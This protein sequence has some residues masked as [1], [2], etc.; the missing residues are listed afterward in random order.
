MVEGETL[1]SCY[2]GFATGISTD[3]IVRLSTDAK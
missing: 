2:R 1:E 3:N